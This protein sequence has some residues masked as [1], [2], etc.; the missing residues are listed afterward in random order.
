MENQEH[1]VRLSAAEIDRKLVAGEDRTDWRRIGRLPEHELEASIDA[2][3][4]GV[5]DWSKAE[6]GLPP[7]KQQ[8]TVRFDLD[9]V[10]FFKAQG[11][12]YQ[13]RMNKVLRRYVEAHRKD[14]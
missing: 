5:F 1:I 3:E 4:E 7:S 11:A 9:V 8:L 12:G 13:T 2:Q 10:E 6:I 14:R